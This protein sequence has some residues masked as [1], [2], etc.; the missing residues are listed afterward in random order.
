M[1]TPLL[2]LLI[3]LTGLCSTLA[4]EKPIDI[5]ADTFAVDY[6]VFLDDEI[7]AS[8]GMFLAKHQTGTLQVSSEPALKLELTLA[9]TP[10][11][12]SPSARNKALRPHLLASTKMF[13]L[14]GDE[15]KLAATPDVAITLNNRATVEIDI[16]GAYIRNRDDI[17]IDKLKIEILVTKVVNRIQGSSLDGAKP[18]RSCDSEYFGEETSSFSA[19]RDCCSVNCLTCCGPSGGSTCWETTRRQAHCSP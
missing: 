1:K 4:A 13:L 3:I 14:D 9:D 16:S 5:R 15:W 2:F 10:D 6:T 11:D 8:P 17:F 18:E 12:L 19:D 7:L